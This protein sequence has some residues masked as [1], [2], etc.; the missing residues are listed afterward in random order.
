MLE[1]DQYGAKTEGLRHMEAGSSEGPAGLPGTSSLAPQPHGATWPPHLPV[2]VS[3]PN[4]RS[5]LTPRARPGHLRVSVTLCACTE[6][7]LTR[8]EPDCGAAGS[9]GLLWQH[10]TLSPQC[11]QASRAGA[12]V[13]VSLSLG[14]KEGACSSVSAESS[15]EGDGITA[16]PKIFCRRGT[17]FRE[18]VHGHTVSGGSWD[19]GSDQS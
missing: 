12:L 6:S 1:C 17:S 13:S 3:V 2:A 11:C 16:K 7:C 10:R 9:T 4:R 8:E 15:R 14:G 18:V 5:T 19:A